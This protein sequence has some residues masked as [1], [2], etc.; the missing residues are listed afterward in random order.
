[1]M[2]H[3]KQQRLKLPDL[4]VV[5]TAFAK[6]RSSTTVCTACFSLLKSYKISVQVIHKY[7]TDMIQISHKYVATMHCNCHDSICSQIPYR[8]DTNSVVF[9]ASCQCQRLSIFRSVVCHL[10][11]DVGNIPRLTHSNALCR[12]LAFLP[13]K[14][15]PWRGGF[16]YQI[17]WL[18]RCLH[19]HLSH[20]FPNVWIF[21]H[22]LEQKQNII[23]LAL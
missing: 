23:P 19:S 12:W 2:H 5:V 14:W 1:M 16:H 8:Y 10:L 13:C 9:I 22:F 15:G 21:L 20:T 18:V 4:K 6:W 17:S 11:D 3:L 7:H